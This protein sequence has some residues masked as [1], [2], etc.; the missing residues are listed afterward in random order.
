[1]MRRSDRAGDGVLI[2]GCSSGIGK[3]AAI[4]IARSGFTAYATVRREAQAE[5]L[6]RLGEPGLVPLCPL[7]LTRAADIAS[8]AETVAADLRRRGRKGLYAI[9]NNAGAGSVAPIELLDLEDLR[10][11]LMTRIVGAVG[12]VQA[13]LP[14]IRE[15]A[16]RLVWIATP[17][18]IPTPYVA[19]IHACDFAANCIARTL[20]IELS[21]WAIPSVLVRCG[22]IRTPAGLRTAEQVEAVLSRPGADI[23]REPLRKWGRE[24]AE[25]DA[26]RTDPERVAAVVVEAL[27]AKRP[28]RRYSVGHMARAAA[29]LEALPQPLADAVLRLRFAS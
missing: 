19:S 6:R 28:R 11:E 1:M 15:A 20:D 29:L 18:T 22:G 9:V 7:D 10:R 14:S 12:L 5:A 25:F 24:M 2:T 13:F 17:A 27:R 8:I 21:R 3:A 26:R 16:G 4:A 23:Y